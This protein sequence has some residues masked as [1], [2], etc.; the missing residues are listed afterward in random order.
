MSRSSSTDC[1]PPSLLVAAVSVSCSPWWSTWGPEWRGPAWRG[2]AW[3]GP[4]QVDARH[5]TVLAKLS[6][7][8]SS[9]NPAPTPL[10]A[11]WEAMVRGRLQRARQHNMRRV[12]WI[13]PNTR[14]PLH[15]SGATYC[16][17]PHAVLS[18][19]PSPVSSASLRAES[20]K[21]EILSRACAD[22]WFRGGE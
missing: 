5:H 12:G 15:T 9:H 8:R 3:G 7:R 2:P 20:P 13:G 1:T 19:T 21:S 6:P 22:Q 11:A 4:N 14:R 18:L 17:D 10:R 16:G